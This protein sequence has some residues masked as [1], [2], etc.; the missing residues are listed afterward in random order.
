MKK[1][2]ILAAALSLPTGSVVEAEVG[3]GE[4]G[5]IDENYQLVQAVVNC[6]LS[7]PQTT[8]LEEGFH[9]LWSVVGDTSYVVDFVIG[10]SSR[11]LLNFSLRRF[12]LDVDTTGMGFFPG[13]AFEEG[14]SFALT[15]QTEYLGETD[16]GEPI[17]VPLT[18]QLPVD[19]SPEGI[20]NSPA[21]YNQ[22]LQDFLRYHCVFS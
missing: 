14:T 10:E 19:G 17:I 3:D 4:I 21:N 12:P 7:T 20:D 13:E 18:V 9:E 1:A 16:F 2:L 15:N 5:L 8:Q 22:A 11:P 6:V